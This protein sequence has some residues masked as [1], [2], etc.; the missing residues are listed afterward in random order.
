MDTKEADAAPKLMPVVATYGLPIETTTTVT[1]Q[2]TLP[3][4]MHAI[5][6]C[7]TSPIRAL[8]HL[9]LIDLLREFFQLVLVPPAVAAELNNPAS[10]VTPVSVGE[11]PFIR[12]RVPSDLDRVKQFGDDP[13][14]LHLGESE[15]LALALEVRADLVLIDENDGRKKVQELGLVPLGVLG[16]LVRAKERGMIDEVTPL[17]HRL[18]HE[19]K[20]Y[21]S[22][23]VWSKIILMTGELS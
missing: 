14:R 22:E 16:L 11:F 23:I 5:V 7:D 21:I 19:L 17:M 9:G 8:A 10:K 2:S 3:L 13:P 15:A 6:V 18:K 1:P 20:F 4:E 12:V